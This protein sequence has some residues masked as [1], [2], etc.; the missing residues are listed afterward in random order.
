MKHRNHDK[1]SNKDNRFICLL[2]HSTK[3]AKPPRPDDPLSSKPL[4]DG[5]FARAVAEYVG[6]DAHALKQ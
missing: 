6:I 3:A 5:Q 2:K 4:K 1:G